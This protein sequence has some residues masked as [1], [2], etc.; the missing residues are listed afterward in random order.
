[1]YYSKNLGLVMVFSEYNG[2]FP[3]WT[4]MEKIFLNE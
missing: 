4:N 2:N 3:A 1:M